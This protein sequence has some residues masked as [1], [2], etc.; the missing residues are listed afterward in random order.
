MR[1]GEEGQIPLSSEKQFE[2][3]GI[4]DIAGKVVCSEHDTLA[5]SG[6]TRRVVQTDHLFIVY[7]RI[8]NILL[9]ESVWIFFGKKGVKLYGKLFCRFI[10]RLEQIERWQREDRNSNLV[11]VEILPRF[12]IDKD[13]SRFAVRDYMFMLSGLN[14]CKMEHYG[15]VGNGGKKNQGPAGMVFSDQCNLVPFSDAQL[16][17]HDVY[18]RNLFGQLTV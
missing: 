9:M 3:M 11:L 13:T 12:L 15:T 10:V 1:H 18:P 7:I 14:S 8:D 5:E 2:G 6:G 16:L 17:V 4:G